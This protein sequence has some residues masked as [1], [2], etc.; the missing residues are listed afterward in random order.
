MHKLISSL[1]SRELG[2]SVGILCHTSDSGLPVLG[3]FLPA[4]TDQD[5]DSSNGCID[6]KCFHPWLPLLVDT[7]G[8][9]DGQAFVACLSSNPKCFQTRAMGFHLATSSTLGSV[10]SSPALVGSI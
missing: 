7:R 8:T 5:A 9:L 1:C 10:S 2:G 4:S 6:W 3:L